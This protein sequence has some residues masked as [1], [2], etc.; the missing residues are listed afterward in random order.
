MHLVGGITAA[1]TS[2]IVDTVTGLPTPP[3][4]LL[5]DPGVGT[6]EIVEV[7][8]AGGTTLTVTRG[9]DGTSAQAHLNG[10]EVRHAY[11]ARDFQDS[12]N[13]EAN[14][15]TAH[16]VTGAVVGT[17]NVQALTNKTLDG[18]LNT[19]TNVPSAGVVGLDA[20]K[21][22]TAAHGVTG[23]V[24]GT[25]DA[26]ALSNKTIN[27]ATNTFTNVPKTALPADVDYA[28]TAQTLTNKSIDGAANTLTSIP[29]ASLTG[30]PAGIQQTQS[31]YTAFTTDG[32]GNATIAYPTAFTSGAVV[33]A[34]PTTGAGGFASVDITAHTLTNF[35]VICHSGTGAVMATSNLS[36]SWIA[37]GVY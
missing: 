22:A 30:V 12:R 9:V 21:A 29:Y 2:L 15:T 35:T 24:V 19:F 7:T 26:Q 32:T 37:A 1:A 28:A 23:A 10:A 31:G 13:H 14:L 4:T 17:T 36:I 11:S 20:H 8:A 25:T 27:G 16:G 3:F 33:V 18:S 5:L 34:A 6:E